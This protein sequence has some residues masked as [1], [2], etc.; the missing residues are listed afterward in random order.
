MFEDLYIPWKSRLGYRHPAPPPEEPKPLEEYPVPGKPCNRT[1]HIVR[2]ILAYAVK[3]L[4]EVSRAI[5]QAIIAYTRG[6]LVLD[7]EGDPSSWK[8][9]GRLS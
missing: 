2:A 8:V 6:Q 9:V 5:A 1:L 3:P 7:L 4:P